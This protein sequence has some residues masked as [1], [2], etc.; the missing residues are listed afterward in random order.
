LAIARVSWRHL[1][2]VFAACAYASST[3]TNPLLRYG[4]DPWVIYDQG[5]YYY[6]ETTGENITL[7]KT[8]DITDLRHAQKKV[9][10]TPPPTGP[11]SHQLW[12]PELHNLNGRWYVYFAADAGA[13]A[14]HHL[15]VLE[16][17]STDPFSDD[18]KF[19]GP[20]QG[21]ENHWAIDPTVFEDRGHYYIIWS[22]WP[23]RRPGVQDLYMAE[24]KTP[25]KVKGKRVLLSTPQYDWERFGNINEGPEI[26]KHASQ[27]FLVYSASGCWTDHYVLGMLVATEGTDLLKAASWRKI[28]HPVFAGSARAHAYGT[29]HNTFFPSPDGTQD[30]IL[31]HANPEPNEGC[32]NFR[33]PRAQPF[34]WDASG[35]P[36]FGTPVPLHQ[37]IPKP[38]GTPEP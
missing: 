9:I 22:G 31:Y 14:T 18:W 15:W 2:L 25:S 20:V 7:W 10:W 12:A 38:S 1:A 27:V 34:T 24:L 19:L 35:F 11:Y 33:S 17:Q 16:D 28:D 36:D 8:R 13:D 37:R 30:W 32:D 29:G 4:A 26:L 23:G 5:F 3:F 21:L 6:T